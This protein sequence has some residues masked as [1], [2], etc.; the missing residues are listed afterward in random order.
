MKTI[1]KLP[2]QI[3]VAIESSLNDDDFFVAARQV[4]DLAPEA[5]IVRKVGIYTLKE[6]GTVSVQTRYQ[7][8]R[9]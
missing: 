3:V 2:K 6:E 9:S 4:A 1:T 5:G 7:V 8:K